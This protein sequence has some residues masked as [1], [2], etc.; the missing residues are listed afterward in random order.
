MHYAT[1]HKRE[2]FCDFVSQLFLTTLLCE[3]LIVNTPVLLLQILSTRIIC[4]EL[5]PTLWAESPQHVKIEDKT[6]FYRLGNI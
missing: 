2:A 6:S 1:S 4:E 5:Y 3:S